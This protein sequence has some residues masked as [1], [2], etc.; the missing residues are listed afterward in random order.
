M[1]ISYNRTFVVAAIKNL[2]VMWRVNEIVENRLEYEVSVFP[3]RVMHMENWREN[4][5]LLWV[6]L[7]DRNLELL[8]NQ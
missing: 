1:K 5:E 2:L 4:R 8:L 7:E 6:V 3:S